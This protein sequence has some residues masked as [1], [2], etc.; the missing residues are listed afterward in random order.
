MTILNDRQIIEVCRAGAITPF[1][2]ELVNPASLDIRIGNTII[3]ENEEGWRDCSIKDCTQN[4]FWVIKPKEFILAC[5]LEEFDLPVDVAAD[6]KLT[7]TA[8][9]SGY[10]AA[11]AHWAEMRFHGSV[12]TLELVNNCR[13]HD[14][15]IFPG[16]IIGQILFHRVEP[17]LV[18]YD[19]KGSYNGDKQAA[20]SKGLKYWDESIK[21]L[22]SC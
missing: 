4:D 14:L 5:T 16:L 6:F 12:L 13:Y 18:G 17:A 7:S 9:R 19:Q 20:G 1:N 8:A 2:E 15:P 11:L 22:P 3:V 21:R 10:D